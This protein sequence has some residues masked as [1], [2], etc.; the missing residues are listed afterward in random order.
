MLYFL[1]RHM[2][3]DGSHEQWVHSNHFFILESYS[4]KLHVHFLF[5]VR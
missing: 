3:T 4:Q 5:I 1:P 2:V